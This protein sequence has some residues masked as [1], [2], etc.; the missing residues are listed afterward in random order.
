M[1]EAAILTLRASRRF[2]RPPGPRYLDAVEDD[3]TQALEIE[4]LASL[5]GR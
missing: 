4:D 1:D 3:A 5:S 2:R